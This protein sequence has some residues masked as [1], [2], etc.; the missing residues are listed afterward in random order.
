MIRSL[1]KLLPYRNNNEN[2]GDSPRKVHMIKKTF[3]GT[4][5]SV[6]MLVQTVVPVLAVGPLS[7]PQTWQQEY[8]EENQARRQERVQ[9]TIER[10]AA[11]VEE[12]FNRHEERLQNWI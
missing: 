10:I 1:P 5:L 11:R 7:T 4:V 8:R 9:S 3:L 12:R 6:A 2:L